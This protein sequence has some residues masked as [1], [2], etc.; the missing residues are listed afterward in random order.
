M[1][2]AI[3]AATGREQFDILEEAMRGVPHAAMHISM[4]ELHV[5]MSQ[6][7]EVVM[8]THCVHHCTTVCTKR[9]RGQ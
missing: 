1:L 7:F 3:K 5:S 4:P 6:L 9:Q 2:I 8:H